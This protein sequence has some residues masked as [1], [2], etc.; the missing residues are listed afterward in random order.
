M[1]SSSRSLL[2][3]ISVLWIPLAFLF[4]GVT[5]LLLPVRL[6]G[7]ATALGLISFAGLA[8]GAVLQPVVGWL[9]DR[10]RHRLDRPV[11][12]AAA[13]APAIVGLWLLAGATGAIA[14]IA[15][16]V[17]VQASGAAIQANQQAFIPERVAVDLRGRASGLK[18][19]FDI[20]GS[21][22]AFVVLGALLAT[23]EVVPAALVIAAVLVV[24]IA[25]ML[26][27]VPRGVG[28]ARAPAAATSS[29]E[30]LRLP[31]GL[32]FL[33]AARFLFLFGTYAVGRFL[34]LLV[35]E[36]LGIAPERAADDAGALLAILTLATAAGALPAG[37][38]ADRVSRRDLMVGGAMLAAIGVL[39]LVPAAGSAGLLAGGLLMSI[40]TAAFVTAN[41][42]ETTAIV[43][44]GEAGRLMGIANVGTALAAAAAGLVGPLIDTAGFGPAL[45]LIGFYV[46]LYRRAA[47][48]AVPARSVARST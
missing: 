25:V 44:A 32:T 39:V 24:A 46:W 1:T 27:G 36:R 43:P 15:G 26:L 28:N 5:V 14:V 37:W 47:Q 4:D 10:W 41:W 29:H 12:A 33:V 35:A 9:S 3:A 8:I 21:F 11:L 42:A 34:L 16:Y 31:P 38:L 22:L 2:V 48:G 20:G 7:D 30:P 6:A 40:G 45:L 19:A 13:A 18:T 23:G 17:I